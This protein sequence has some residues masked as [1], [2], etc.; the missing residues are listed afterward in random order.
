MSTT[1][2]I[3]SIATSWNNL[4]LNIIKS[5]Y[6]MFQSRIKENAIKSPEYYGEGSRKLSIL[7]ARLR[8]QCRSLNSDIFRINITHDSQWQ[9]GSPFKDSNHY[10]MECPLHQNE[11]FKVKCKCHNF[12]FRLTYFFIVI[13]VP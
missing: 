11:N 6:I 13:L 4:D 5:K 2:F 7:H 8:H 1:S 10:I 3:P 12:F 9:C